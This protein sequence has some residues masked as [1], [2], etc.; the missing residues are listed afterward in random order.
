MIWTNCTSKAKQHKIEPWHH[1]LDLMPIANKKVK[2]SNPVRDI[3]SQPRVQLSHFIK[4]LITPHKAEQQV[5]AAHI[6]MSI[7]Q[8]KTAL[9]PVP[10][11]TSECQLTCSKG[12]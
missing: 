8:V 10:V 11:R 12:I 7:E 6:L 4:N 2:Y 9:P 5:T 3:H 1:C